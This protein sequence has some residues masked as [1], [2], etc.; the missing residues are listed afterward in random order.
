MVGRGNCLAGRVLCFQGDAQPLCVQSYQHTLTVKCF[1]GC[2]V[3]ASLGTISFYQLPTKNKVLM[4]LE[5]S[6]SSTA[7]EDPSKSYFLL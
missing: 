2:I 7:S 5:T 6:F 1:L 4:W 3:S